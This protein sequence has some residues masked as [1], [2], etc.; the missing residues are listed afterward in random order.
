M[1][2]ALVSGHDLATPIVV[3]RPLEVDTIIRTIVHK[4]SELGKCSP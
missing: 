2:W 3:T 4:M 1:S